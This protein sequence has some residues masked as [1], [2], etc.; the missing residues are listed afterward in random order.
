MPHPAV[1]PA[2][3]MHPQF[4]YQPYITESSLTPYH[5]PPPPP[6]SAATAGEFLYHNCTLFSSV[7]DHNLTLSIAVIGS[8]KGI[9]EREI[10]DSRQQ[11]I[12]NTITMTPSPPL[13]LRKKSSPHSRLNDSPLITSPYVQTSRNFF[14]DEPIQ[15]HRPLPPRIRV[16]TPPYASKVPQ[17]GEPVDMYIPAQSRLHME[18]SR[19]G[20][21]AI[22]AHDDVENDVPTRPYTDTSYVGRVAMQDTLAPTESEL[23]Y[24]RRRIVRL[25]DD[26]T[27]AS[28]D[29]SP[30]QMDSPPLGDSPPQGNL[31]GTVLVVS[32]ANNIEFDEI[33]K[34]GGFEFCFIF[35]SKCTR[36]YGKAC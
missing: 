11:Q 32:V 27:V 8:A 20:G 28:R 2:H 36:L 21:N 29:S 12:V 30:S 6:S 4:M 22:T 23:D 14:Y 9:P 25:R 10:I 17:Q 15:A 18:T 31:D 33:T 1:Q 5:I 13:E 34:K 16:S 26:N 7:T 24:S 3:Y 19:F 35:C